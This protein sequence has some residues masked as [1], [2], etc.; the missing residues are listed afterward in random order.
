MLTTTIQYGVHYLQCNKTLPFKS[1]M[2]AY[3]EVNKL[4]QYGVPAEVRC[5]I[6]T[7]GVWTRPKKRT[8]GGNHDLF[9]G[10]EVKGGE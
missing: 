7:R 4:R 9:S 2:A 1:E 3:A 10:A 5:Q 6:V 8:Y